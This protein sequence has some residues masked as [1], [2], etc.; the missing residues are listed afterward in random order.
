MPKPPRKSETIRA[1]GQVNVAAE[2]KPA[3]KVAKRILVRHQLNKAVTAVLIELQNLLPR[4]RTRLGPDVRMAAIR[5]RMLGIELKL[6]N[7]QSGKLIHQREQ[8][9]HGRNL[10]ARDVNHHPPSAKIRPILDLKTR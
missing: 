4:Q 6:V 1:L 8:R 10:V 2:L 3:L 7:L 5:K 9:G